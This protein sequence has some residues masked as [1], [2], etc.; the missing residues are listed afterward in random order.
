VRG[1]LELVRYASTA[2]SSII[3][4][5]RGSTVTGKGVTCAW[6]GSVDSLGVAKKRKIGKEKITIMTRKS[7]ARTERERVT[8]FLVL[9]GSF[10]D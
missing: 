7:D 4:F 2:G 10:L 5:L 6:V 1:E 9:V 8:I 3:A